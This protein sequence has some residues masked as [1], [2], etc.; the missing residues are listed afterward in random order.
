MSAK[1]S[2]RDW[3]INLE[4][5]RN[6]A[7]MNTMLHMVDM[8]GWSKIDGSQ[9]WMGRDG[10]NS[11][12]DHDLISIATTSEYMNEGGCQEMDPTSWTTGDG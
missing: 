3:T 4:K 2:I 12:M 5:A 8:N 1:M 6:G 10:T 9:G 7:D 11:E